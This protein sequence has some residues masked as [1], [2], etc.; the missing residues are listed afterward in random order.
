[1]KLVG[2][3]FDSKLNWSCMLKIKV[4]LQKGGVS[5]ELCTG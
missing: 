1:M 5:L 2:F 4:L 3:T